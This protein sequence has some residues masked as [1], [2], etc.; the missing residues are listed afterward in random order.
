MTQFLI[1]SVATAALYALVGAGFSLIYRTS[2]FFHFALAATITVGAYVGYVLTQSVGLPLWLAASLSVLACAL[3]GVCMSVT[4]FVPLMRRSASPLVLLLASLGLHVV[5]QNLLSLV[6]SDRIRSMH[7]GGVAEGLSVF[8]ARISVA[9]AAMIIVS[10]AFITG[11]ATLLKAT[12]FG[13]ELRAVANN[14]QLAEIVGIDS[15]K[16][17]HAAFGLGS[18]F[19]AMAGLLLAL[20]F[21]VSPAM[22]MS[23]FMMGLIAAIIGSTRRLAGTVSGAL[24]LALVQNTAAHFMSAQWQDGIAF[25]LLVVF[26]LVR[27]YGVLGRETTSFRVRQ[28]A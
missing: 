10:C 26:L 4:L 8:G 23:P 12:R 2:G 25:G 17:I 3:L 6:F 22:G 5:I 1:N 28:L 21:H 16:V 24:L 11:A 7:S 19:A 20:D 9:Q 13:R 18:G 27:P 14:A 15:G